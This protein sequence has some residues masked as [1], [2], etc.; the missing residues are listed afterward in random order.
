MQSSI[1]PNEEKLFN[2][3]IDVRKENKHFQLLKTAE[4]CG[5]LSQAVVKMINHIEDTKISFKIFEDIKKH[6]QYL[7]NII[8]EMT[9]VEIQL[10]FVRLDLIKNYMNEEEFEKIKN[11]QYIL[12]MNKIRR[13]LKTLKG[14]KEDGISN[15]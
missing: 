1:S 15:D 8:E 9:D 3:I 10:H 2:E 6:K 13:R 7:N 12:K 4:E 14:E 11:E 5:E